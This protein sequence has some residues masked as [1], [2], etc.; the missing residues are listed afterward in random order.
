MRKTLVINAVGLTQSLLGDH[1]PRLRTFA[2]AWEVARDRS[3]APR[4]HLQRAIDLP[5]RQMAD[6]ARHRRQRL[7]LPRHVRSAISGSRRTSSSSRRRSGM[8]AKQRRPD[9]Y[10]REHLLVVR[11]VFVGGLHRHAAPAVPGRRSQAARRL[12]APADASRRAAARARAVSAVQILGPGHHRSK[13]T[14][15]IARAAMRVDEQFDPTLT[16][17]YL[18]HLDYDFQRHRPG[19]CRKSR[20]DLRELDALC[21]QLFDHFEKRDARDRRPVRST[22]LNRVDRSR[23]TSTACLRE[24]AC[25]PCA[26]RSAASCSM[27]ARARRS[28][29]PTI[30][31][32]TCM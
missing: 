16:L 6:R 15:W 5:H 10:L 13:P 8:S 3:R 4:R 2:I 26:R 23:S 14:A 7:V 25:S 24:R 27:P 22:A 11:D 1:T 31:S 28:R 20:E 21:G 18:P 17:V 29:W 12:D 9:V 19:P 30:R 32:R